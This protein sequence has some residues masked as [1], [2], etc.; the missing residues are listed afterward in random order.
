MTSGRS[1]FYGLRFLK[2]PPHRPPSESIFTLALILKSYN[3]LGGGDAPNVDSNRFRNAWRTAFKIAMFCCVLS[4]PVAG[5][6]EVT[7][8]GSSELAGDQIGFGFAGHVKLGHWTP[9][10]IPQKWAD[11]AD[12]FRFETIDGDESPVV[13]SGPIDPGTKSTILY[14]R[15]GKKF[16]R[17]KLQL[18]YQGKIVRSFAASKSEIENL[19][20]SRSTELMT[21]ILSGNQDLIAKLKTATASQSVDDGTLTV[22][23]DSIA[24][25]PTQAIGWQSVNRLII[26]PTSV[27][28]IHSASPELADAIEEW[29]KSG[30]DLILIADPGKASLFKNQQW[31]AS[32]TGGLIGSTIQMQTSRDLERFV[33]TSRRQL[34]GRD[35]E[36]LPMLKVTPADDAIVVA[37]SEGNP[38]L[39]R[40]AFGFGRTSFCTLNLESDR[41]QQWP[42]Y[43]GLIEK[44][45]ATDDR[46]SSS[47]SRQESRSPTTGLTHYGYTDLLGQLRVPLDDFSTVRFLAFT[48]IA[49]LIS[50]YILCV[51]AGDFFFLKNVIGKME[52]TWVTFPIITLTFCGLAFGI[53]MVTRPHELQINQME[54]IDFDLADNGSRG[55]AWVNLYAPTGKKVDI[56]LA[57][58]TSL[59][60]DVGRQVVSWQ[61]LP[62][63][64]LGGMENEV[65]TGFK[66]LA[67]EQTIAPAAGGGVDVALQQLPLQVASTKPLLIQYAIEAPEKLSSQLSAD[68]DRLEGTFKNPLSVPIYN[69]KIF[70]GDYVYL[71]K[72]PL[73]GDVV[74]LVESDAKERTL[75]SYLNRRTAKSAQGSDVGRSQNRPW[76]P[77]EKNLTRIADVMMFYEAAGGKG[78]TGLTNGYHRTIDFS[79]LLRLGKAVLVGQI[80]SGSHIKIDQQDV[81]DRYDSN[82]TM[83]RIV[84]PVAKE[85]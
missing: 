22:A 84:L 73:Q 16:G 23:V 71:L 39:I 61:G 69:A 6:D 28:D 17:I 15:F 43:P 64:G 62:G 74:T 37:M 77:Q 65:S 19:T 21:V 12:E 1:T 33:G 24:A 60:L 10:A 75:R 68:R 53:S 34:I 85:N 29:V 76:D 70:F 42:S 52:S 83:V 48:L 56:E 26:S 80:E 49:V 8:N 9:I 82:I 54:I 18:L 58:Q 7:T 4:L 67:Y 50:I 38:I 66:R 25:L 78:Y 35:E 40:S 41:L 32:L 55:T 2:I 72:K 57:S 79:K 46:R 27:A 63:D 14:V 30:G 44:V 11:Q 81:T 47:P 5:A 13:Y 3:A 36:P 31:L 45:I 51:T 59:G 20:F